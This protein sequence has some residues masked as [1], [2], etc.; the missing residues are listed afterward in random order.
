M[1]GAA[2]FGAFLVRGSARRQLKAALD[3]LEETLQA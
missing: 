1:R 2:K 3:G